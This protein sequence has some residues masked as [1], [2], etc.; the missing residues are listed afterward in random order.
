MSEDHTV[1]YKELWI[2]WKWSSLVVSNSL[3]PNGLWPTT[4]LCPWDFPGKSTGV[5]CHFLLQRIFPTQGSNSGVPHCRQML[6][7]LNHQGSLNCMSLYSN[8]GFPGDSVVKNPTANA[9]D[10]GDA[11]LIPGSGRSPGGGNGNPLH[12]CGGNSID[13]GGYSPCGHKELDKTEHAHTQSIFRLRIL[14][15]SEAMFTWWLLHYIVSFD[16]VLL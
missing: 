11:A 5:G 2:V 16:S 14:I 7:H 3:W 12:S 6:Y 15:K 4:L 10:T 8:L 13:R 9:G 1:C